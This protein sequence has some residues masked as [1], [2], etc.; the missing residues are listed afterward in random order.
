MT[1]AILRDLNTDLSIKGDLLIEAD[2]NTVLILSSTREIS[3]VLAKDTA[4]RQTSFKK[5][6]A[7]LRPLYKDIIFVCNRWYD[8]FNSFLS[9]LDVTVVYIDAWALDTYKRIY[10]DKQCPVKESHVL[11]QNKSFLFLIGKPDREHRI[12]LLHELVTQ[13]VISNK[14]NYTLQ[15][16]NPYVKEECAKILNMNKDE[17]QKFADSYTRLLDMEYEYTATDTIQH[18]I[19]IPFKKE[20]FEDSNFQVIAESDTEFSSAWITEKTWISIIN[21]MPFMLVGNQHMCKRLEDRGFKTFREYMA[22]PDYDSEE[23]I[24]KR[25]RIAAENIKYWESNIFDYEEEILRDIEHNYI[26]YHKIVRDNLKVIEKLIE[27]YNINIDPHELFH[28]Y[29]NDYP[30]KYLNKEKL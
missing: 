16:A 23:D 8:Q 27:D 29:E 20:I 19:G 1:A 25:V 9:T 17:F 26:L 2:P 3:N 11:K 5:R 30:V 10:L 7:Q 14:T 18:F 13:G 4:S 12:G 24:Q 21:K 28:G 6:L 22:Y 15:L